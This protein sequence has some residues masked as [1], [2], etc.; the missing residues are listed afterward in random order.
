MSKAIIYTKYCL[1]CMWPDEWLSVTSWLQHQGIS[2]KIKRT[3]YRP[4]WHKV[5]TKLYDGD[6][7][8]A[9]VLLDGK[10]TDFMDF[11]KECKNKL[12]EL[13]KTKVVDDDVQG[14]SKAKRANRKTRVRVKTNTA[15]G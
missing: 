11:A 12:I 13:G 6:D 9:F 10:V 4:D 2:L 15:S 7:Y 14:L 1:D 5:A 3:T 8:R